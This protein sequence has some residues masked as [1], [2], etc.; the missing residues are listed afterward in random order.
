MNRSPTAGNG[1]GR[2]RAGRFSA[3]NKL[4]K[5]NPFAK[6]T[7]DLRVALFRAVTKKDIKAIILKMVEAAKRGDMI[8]AREV[9]DRTIGKASNTELLQRVEH[10]ES[11]RQKRNRMTILNR[12]E[13]L[14]A[15]SSDMQAG[16]MM[17]KL[18][19]ASNEIP[20]DEPSLIE[21]EQLSRRLATLEFDR[22]ERDM[23]GGESGDATEETEL[24]QRANDLYVDM[25]QRHGKAKL[26]A[27]GLLRTDA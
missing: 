13:A 7:Q 3:G 5:G 11:L 24:S 23:F 20:Q 14:E 21:L 19:D 8:A 22:A 10:L 12:I 16:P 6:Q 25:F 1:N 4:A 17:R 27:L 2:D 18:M 9:L 26:A 15:S